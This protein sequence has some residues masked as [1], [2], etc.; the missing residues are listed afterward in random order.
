VRAELVKIGMPSA[1]SALWSQPVRG[2][3]A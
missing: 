1:A 2:N 3:A